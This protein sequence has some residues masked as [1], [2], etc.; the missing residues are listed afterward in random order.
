L[1]LIDDFRNEVMVVFL[2]QVIQSLFYRGFFA[3]LFHGHSVVVQ[4][5]VLG[6]SVFENYED[7]WI[8]TYGRLVKVQGKLLWQESLW[9]SLGFL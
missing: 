6:I 5:L 4:F 1:S 3:E 9:R 8:F 2:F 7:E